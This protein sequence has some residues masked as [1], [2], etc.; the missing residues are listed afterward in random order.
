MDNSD[1]SDNQNSPV[2]EGYR[3]VYSLD[4]DKPPH[5]EPI[6][7]GTPSPPEKKSGCEITYYPPDFNNPLPDGTPRR[8]RMEMMDYDTDML[9]L[10]YPN[11][12]LEARGLYTE[13]PVTGA[14]AKQGHWRYYNEDG[15]IASE[16]EYKDNKKNGLWMDYK[17]G[18]FGT[19]KNNKMHGRWTIQGNVTHYLNGEAFDLG[20]PAALPLMPENHHGKKA[21]CQDF[22]MN[23]DELQQQTARMAKSVLAN[24][25]HKN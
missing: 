3:R 11:D 6:S 9:F 12:S 22:R 8:V 7:S 16:G 18:E 4:D 1:L 20:K 21:S 10:F 25:T 19:Y 15:S 2:P 23:Q 5:L 17:S 24:R 13:D 14:R